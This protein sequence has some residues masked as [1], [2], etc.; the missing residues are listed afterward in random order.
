MHKNT[1]VYIFKSGNNKAKLYF[2]E[3]ANCRYLLRLEV[4]NPV[5]TKCIS[6]L[7]C[8]FNG[9][10]IAFDDTKEEV[11]V[12]VDVAFSVLKKWKDSGKITDDAFNWATYKDYP[13][14]S[15]YK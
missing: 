3:A 15:L 2:R 13:I 10:E 7:T 11:S 5:Y 6:K 14:R 4:Y 1:N 8:D 12:F 9:K